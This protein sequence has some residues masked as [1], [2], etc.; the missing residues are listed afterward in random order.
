[1]CFPCLE[2]LLRTGQARRDE[3]VVV[4]T[5]GAAQKDPEVMAVPLPR[6]EKE[7]PVDYRRLT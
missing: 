7:R 4:V 3:E 6:L 2:E 5:I 1:M